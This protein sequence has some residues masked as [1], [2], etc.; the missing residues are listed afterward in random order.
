MGQ[1][2]ARLGVRGHGGSHA[3]FW[4]AEARSDRLATAAVRRRVRRV[5]PDQ[6]PRSPGQRLRPPSRRPRCGP[7]DLGGGPGTA[8][9]QGGG[10]GDS[11]ANTN[12]RV[13]HKSACDI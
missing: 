1:V 8:A 10:V 3:F 6:H 7:R 13:L 2:P 12:V 9:H 5:A 4:G 11:P